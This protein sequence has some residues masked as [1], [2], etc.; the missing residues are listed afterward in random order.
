MLAFVTM[1]LAGL[2]YGAFPAIAVGAAVT[3]FR[4]GRSFDAMLFLMQRAIAEHR[5]SMA[6]LAFLPME[7]RELL[8]AAIWPVWLPPVIRAVQADPEEEPWT[9]PIMPEGAAPLMDAWPDDM[10]RS[11]EATLA[12]LDRV[13]AVNTLDAWKTIGD[14]VNDFDGALALR[15]AVRGWQTPGQPLSADHVTRI[16]LLVAQVIT[17]AAVPDVVGAEIAGFELVRIPETREIGLNFLRDLAVLIENG[18]I[19]EYEDA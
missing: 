2:L 9:S 4:D 18:M 12:E 19:G 10:E 1:F 3:R 11:R 15:G 6:S 17:L 5:P 8:V 14:G 13:L 7:A 16:E